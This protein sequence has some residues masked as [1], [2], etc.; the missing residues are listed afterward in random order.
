MLVPPAAEV[1][2]A[3]ARA[4]KPSSSLV[5]RRRWQRRLLVALL[6]V[7]DVALCIVALRLAQWTSISA[8]LLPELRE[9]P[10]PR[11]LPTL[12]LW[13]AIVFPTL[14][15]RGLYRFNYRDGI[16]SLARAATS[17]L[18]AGALFTVLVFFLALPITRI[19]VALVIVYTVLLLGSFRLAFRVLAARL[20]PLSRRV[21]VIGAGPTAESIARMVAQ[22]WRRGFHLVSPQADA[23]GELAG[24]NGLHPD[25]LPLDTSDLT[26]IAS[27]V[28][29]LDID[30]IV[31]TREWYKQ[32]CPDVE[33]VFTMLNRLPALVHVAPDPPEL[34]THMSVEDFSGLPVV[35]LS[36]LS[37]PRAQM[38]V[39]RLFDIVA[40]A[41][42]ILLLSPLLLLIAIAIRV[43]SRGPIIFRQTRIGQYYRL[44]TIYKFRTMW[45]GEHPVPSDGRAHKQ[46]GDLRVTTV[47]RWLRRASLDELPQLFNVLKGDMSLVG[48]RP[49]LPAIAAQ[50]RP[51]QYGRLL[52]PQGIT[53]WWQ[54]NG[55]G[56]RILHEHTEDDI[57]YVRNYSLLLDARILLMTARAIITGRGA[58]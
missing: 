57:Y 53:G 31:I 56:E 41:L 54:V 50:Y 34:M 37:L 20:H 42:L 58:F 10:V 33:H 30:D 17:V 8:W 44:F 40:A 11:L 6:L 12:L 26:R 14:A 13:L 9:G 4:R 7:A 48:P 5:A 15:W 27:Y 19:F 28:H 21:L 1:L 22:Y 39:K 24:R 43:T 25:P 47:G 35:S 36:P 29:A 3:A 49:E 46:R 2:S 52:M 16:Y 18:L 55:R 38:A 23:I 32:H 51:W 45:V